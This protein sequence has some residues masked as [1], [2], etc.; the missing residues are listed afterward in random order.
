MGE[1]SKVDWTHHSHNPWVGCSK[2]SAACAFCYAESWGKRSG[3]VAWGPDA[4]R[5]LTSE[6]NWHQPIK[7]N[8]AAAKAGVRM[9]VFCASL[10]DVFDDHPS[11]K[12]EWR[13]RL[14]ALIK[15]TPNLEWIIVTKRIGN[16]AEMLPDD[17]GPNGYPN[18]TV[19][20]SVT[21]QREADRD[22]PVLL[23]LP[24]R[25]RGL[26]MEPLLEAVDIRRWLPG[27]YECSSMCGY[28]SASPSMI[29][30]CHACGWEGGNAKEFCPACGRQD[31]THV[32]PDCGAAV[33]TDHPDTP[34]LDWVIVGGESGPHARPMH[35][36]WVR[37]LREQCANTNTPF[38]FKQHGEWIGTP[39]LQ[40]L[41]GGRGP[42]FGAY[43]HCT[44]DMD[45]EA[46][47]VG[48]K[49]AGHM[50]DGREHRDIPSGMIQLA[51]ALMAA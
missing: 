31:W 4:E 38:F 37:S 13:A 1:N 12:P 8:R 9:R 19:L 26:S 10:A 27:S 24:C 33:L 51:Q 50:L 36:D 2:M 39:D 40:N 42:G 21:S 35:P 5:K 25:R 30:R 15:A 17:W 41:P 47:R 49:V 29:E 48:K 6:S 14:W 44:Y 32:C 22:I 28:R 11:I 23:A 7:W 16:A 3:M 18:V 43:D 34:H 46:V 45:H 20:I